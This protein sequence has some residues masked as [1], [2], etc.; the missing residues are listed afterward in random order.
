MS[1]VDS[2]LLTWLSLRIS[3]SPYS[4]PEL[5][6]V[7]FSGHSSC[8]HSATRRRRVDIFRIKAPVRWRQVSPLHNI[9]HNTIMNHLRLQ[10]IT[11]SNRNAR[12]NSIVRIPLIRLYIK[13]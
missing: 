12:M 11:F 1:L 2:R 3:A 8:T 9:K 6:S 4:E 10:K 13:A 5:A 7:S